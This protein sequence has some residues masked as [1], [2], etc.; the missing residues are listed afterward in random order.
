VLESVLTEETWDNIGAWSGSWPKI[1]LCLAV[2]C[3]MFKS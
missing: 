3:N 2:Q 1:P